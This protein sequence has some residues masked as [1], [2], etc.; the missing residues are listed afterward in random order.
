[1]SKS[2]ARILLVVFTLTLFVFVNRST[3]QRK[4]ALQLSYDSWLATVRDTVESEDASIAKPALKMELLS[5][6]PELQA[7]W[8]ISSAGNDDN[9]RK[10]VRLMELASE[11]SLFSFE[12]SKTAKQSNS[13]TLSIEGGSRRFDT[14]FTREAIEQNVKAQSFLKLFELYAAHTP[15][16]NLSQQ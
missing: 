1:M 13:L 16:P 14:R 7:N 10:I 2:F 11:A 9:A 5:T 12:A 15:T 6:Y 4:S 3:E 8:I